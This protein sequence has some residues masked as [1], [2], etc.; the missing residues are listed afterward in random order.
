MSGGRQG[1]EAGPMYL[2]VRFKEEGDVNP[3]SLLKC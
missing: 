3:L 1:E 2:V